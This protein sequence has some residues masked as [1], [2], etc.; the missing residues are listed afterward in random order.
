MYVQEAEGW[1][2]CCVLTLQLGILVLVGVG[3]VVSR[4]CLLLGLLLTGVEGTSLLGG[5]SSLGF[6]TGA[7]EQSSETV[8]WQ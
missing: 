4:H 1:H 3:G 2:S 5:W 8:V 6:R 7:G